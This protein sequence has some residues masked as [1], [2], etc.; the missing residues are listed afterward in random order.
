M[1]F[2]RVYA[3][4]N[5]I[6]PA[7]PHIHRVLRSELIKLENP[8]E[9]NKDE[10]RLVRRQDKHDDEMIF[11]SG[12]LARF[13]FLYSGS[14]SPNVC[15]YHEGDLVDGEE[16]VGRSGRVFHERVTTEVSV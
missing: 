7:P 9:L 3:N 1:Y 10:E 16:V 5:F 2:V 8:Y 14:P 15:V 11:Q 12:E 4:E 6:I 13:K